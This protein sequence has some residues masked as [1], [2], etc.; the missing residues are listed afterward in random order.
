MTNQEA[1]DD[2][3]ID[4]DDIDQNVEVSTSDGYCEAIVKPKCYTRRWQTVQFIFFLSSF[5][6]ISFCLLLVFYFFIVL[7]HCINYFNNINSIINF[8]QDIES[9]LDVINQNMPNYGLKKQMI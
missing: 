5:I 4:H 3:L 7:C 9:V 6:V 8:Y 1:T 2:D